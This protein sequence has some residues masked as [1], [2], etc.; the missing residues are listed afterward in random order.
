MRDYGKPCI[1]CGGNLGSKYDAGHFYSVGSS[2][3]L[4]FNEY[5][6]HAQCVHC[7]QHLH[8]NLI[9]YS[10]QLPLRIGVDMFETLK[11][12]RNIPLKL[13]TAEI[14]EQISYYKLK[15]KDLSK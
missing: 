12:I 2:P 8:G 3:N 4:R 11:S 7:N 10:E 1:S 5:N 13:T 6:V 14:K 9:L 15:I